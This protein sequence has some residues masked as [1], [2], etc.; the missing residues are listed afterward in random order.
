MHELL[1][2]DLETIEVE[3]LANLKVSSNGRSF[4]YAEPEKK[5]EEDLDLTSDK[6]ILLE[7]LPEEIQTSMSIQ[8]T[9]SD[10]RVVIRCPSIEYH[11]ASGNF[12][13]MKTLTRKEGR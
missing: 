8:Q 9:N 5:E 6:E 7:K 1:F 11:I 10:Y 13:F 3:I 2:K 4:V 12:L